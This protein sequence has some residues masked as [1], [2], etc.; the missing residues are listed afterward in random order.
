MLKSTTDWSFEKHMAEGKIRVT[1]MRHT[2]ADLWPGSRNCKVLSV[3]KCHSSAYSIN[4][5]ASL[6]SSFK[7]IK[8]RL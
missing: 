1:C 4:R 2:A 6:I 7:K 3:E 8:V 5:F